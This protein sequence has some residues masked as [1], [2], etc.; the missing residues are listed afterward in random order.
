MGRGRQIGYEEASEKLKNLLESGEKFGEYDSLRYC[1][2][3]FWLKLLVHSDGVYSVHCQVSA[4]SEQTVAEVLE[5]MAKANY[6][7]DAILYHCY[8]KGYLEIQNGNDKMIYL[9]RIL[10]T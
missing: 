4:H 2:Q 9:V 3:S 5:R 1:I 6:G 7:S 8:S 10:L